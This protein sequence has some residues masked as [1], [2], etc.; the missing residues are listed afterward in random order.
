VQCK[1]PAGKCQ[2]TC[3]G[4]SCGSSCCTE[5]SGACPGFSACP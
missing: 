4:P 3:S 1:A 2:L 5:S